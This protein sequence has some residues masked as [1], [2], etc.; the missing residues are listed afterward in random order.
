MND[1][2]MKRLIA[3]GI[4]LPIPQQPLGIYKAVLEA[5]SMLHVSMQGPAVAEQPKRL[6]LLG[7]EL[8]LE[9]GRI[10]AR[11]ATLNALAQI[12]QYLGSFDRVKQIVRLE[13]YLACIDEFTSH[14]TVLDGASELLADVF[15]ERSGHVR[16]LCGVRNLPGNFPVAIVLTVELNSQ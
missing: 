6:G 5:G 12:H 1:E 16:S 4:D 14:P 15:R 10:A 8:T 13:G 9:D 7:K 2:A 3:L 11:L